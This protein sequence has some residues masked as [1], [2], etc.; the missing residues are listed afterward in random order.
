MRAPDNAV[1]DAMTQLW[2]VTSTAGRLLLRSS[3]AVSARI[4]RGWYVCH[5]NLDAMRLNKQS[6]EWRTVVDASQSELRPL[7]QCSRQAIQLNA[8]AENVLLDD[9][10]YTHHAHH[11]RP[12]LPRLPQ[13]TSLFTS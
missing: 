2:I 10:M 3:F 4:S 6:P 5:A 8:K 11:E 7:T 9:G 12:V 1:H 13:L